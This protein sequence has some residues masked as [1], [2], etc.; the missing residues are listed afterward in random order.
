MEQKTSFLL[1]G[2]MLWDP[3]LDPDQL[4]AEFLLLY[5]GP[6]GAPFVRL[7]LLRGTLLSSESFKLLRCLDPFM[8]CTFLGAG[9]PPPRFPET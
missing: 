2:E 4:I 7:Y 6:V 5:Y 1:Q 9:T 8:T 3:T